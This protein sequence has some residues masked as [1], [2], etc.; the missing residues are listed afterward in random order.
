M[1]RIRLSFFKCFDALDIEFRP[2]VNLLVGDNASGKTSL[3]TACKYVLSTF[4]SGFSTEDT[5]W[6]SPGEND[7]MCEETDG[8]ISADRPLSIRFE[9]DVTQFPELSSDEALKPYDLT[10]EQEIRK[11][12]YKNSRPLLSGLRDMKNYSESLKLSYAIY[13]HNSNSEIQHKS[14]PLFVAYTTEDIHTRRKIEQGKFLA[15]AKKRSFGYYECLEADGLLKYWLK[16]LLVLQEAETRYHQEI[17]MVRSA[18]INTLGPQGCD[19]IYDMSVR[20]NV[21]KVFYTLKDGRVVEADLLSD[22]YKR[23]V[24]IVTDMAARCSILNRSYFGTDAIIQTKGTAIIDEIDLHLHPSL[25]AN[26]IKGLR[27]GFPGIQFIISTH[28]PMVMSGIKSDNENVVYRMV[29]DTSAKKYSIS[30]VNPYGMDISSISRLILD[31][32]D[33]NAEV[34]SKIDNL[35]DAIDEE[36][37]A[38]ASRLL[39]MLTDELGNNIREL[40]EARTII[41][42]ETSGDEINS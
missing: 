21:K 1:K 26:I 8:V 2:G 9:Q 18:V 11:K 7:F 6:L 36:N 40:I 16:R 31:L 15:Y 34:Q 10:L 12:S 28:S 14:L 19:I 4:F 42:L 17:D 3:L 38:E 22:G 24:S 5:K 37:F 27:N 41:N 39:D 29:Y 23:L 13:D 25:Q 32:T 33:R 20:P 35:F 30:E